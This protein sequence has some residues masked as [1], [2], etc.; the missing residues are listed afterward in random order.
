MVA[1]GPKNYLTIP[2]WDPRNWMEHVVERS[3][4]SWWKVVMAIVI[5]IFI[6]FVVSNIFHFPIY[7]EEYSQLTNIFQ[8]FKP[9]TSYDLYDVL[10]DLMVIYGTSNHM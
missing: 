10:N 1:T 8:G 9:P 2:Q 7:L 6:W 3:G 5:M 4:T